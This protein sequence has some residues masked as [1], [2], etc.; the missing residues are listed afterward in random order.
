MAGVGLGSS[1]PVTRGQS[2]RGSGNVAGR[3][4]RELEREVCK[5]KVQDSSRDL[6]TAL[7]Y[8]HTCVLIGQ[9][10]ASEPS[11]NI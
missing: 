6:D 8:S 7:V 11:Q 10:S 9:A 2:V 3:R 1:G 5:G 4:V